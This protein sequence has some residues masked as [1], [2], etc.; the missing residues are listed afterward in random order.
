MSDKVVQQ[1]MENSSWYDCHLGIPLCTLVGV[2]SS[3]TYPTFDLPKYFSVKTCAEI[4]WGHAVNSSQK[5]EEALKSNIMLGMGTISL[6]Y[7][8]W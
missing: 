2:Y 5:L 8:S 4:P 3:M 6:L 7:D 1:S